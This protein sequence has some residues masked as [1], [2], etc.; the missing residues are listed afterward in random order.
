MEE[1]IKE[2]EMEWP[3]T[4]TSLVI[5][6]SMHEAVRFYMVEEDIW[7]PNNYSYIL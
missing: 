3:M 1:N 4:L 7:L 2:S 5:I 6:S